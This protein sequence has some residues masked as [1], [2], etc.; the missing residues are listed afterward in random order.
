MDIITLLLADC[1]YI[2]MQTMK[3]I[4]R[5]NIALN[6]NYYNHINIITKPYYNLDP[7]IFYTDT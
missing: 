2:Y 4:I 6:N 7:H 5:G 1:A 3:Y